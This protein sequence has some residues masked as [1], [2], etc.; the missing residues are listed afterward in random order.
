M[1]PVP[2]KYQYWY[3]WLPQ[4]WHTFFL[5]VFQVFFFPAIKLIM[6]SFSGTLPELHDQATKLFQA[7]ESGAGSSDD[8][9]SHNVTKCIAMY[10]QC[11][12]LVRGNSIF[13]ENEI[14]IDLSTRRLSYLLIPLRLAQLQDYVTV[15]MSSSGPVGRLR[16]LETSDLYYEQYLQRIMEYRLANASDVKRDEAR[17][18][19]KKYSM[20]SGSDAGGADVSSAM[21]MLTMSGMSKESAEVARQQK[22][23]TYQR[24]KLA[25]K[26]MEEII[27]IKLNRNQKKGSLF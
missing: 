18:E 24:Q 10:E 4:V 17:K 12:S 25:K 1:L 7:C 14:L 27:K 16:L 8:T 20:G 6:T 15:D 22:I 23:E 26:R 11:S 2:L 19:M 13:S 3:T 9:H 5:M 21:S